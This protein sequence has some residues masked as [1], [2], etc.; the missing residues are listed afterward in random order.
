MVLDQFAVGVDRHH[1]LDLRVRR[2][3]LEHRTL[4]VDDEADTR[5]G[6]LRVAM[7]APGLRDVRERRLRLVVLLPADAILEIEGRA[8]RRHLVRNP[9]RDDV[10]VRLV[11]RR[12]L[13][14]FDAAAAPVA[15]R[16]HPRARPQLVARLQVL[17]VL[18]RAVALH[19][20]EA[21]RIGQRERRDQQPLRIHE[22]PRDPLAGAG[23][24]QQ[25]VGVVDLGPVV[26]R[27]RVLVLAEVRTCSSAA[28]APAS[29]RS[30]AGTRAPSRASASRCPAAAR[31]D[32]RR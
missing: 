28:R 20:A 2:Q 10:V 31:S 27:L 17:V 9:E 22:R 29:S 4:E 6:R 23:L 3:A 5:V 12:D 25:H 30:R 11:G 15:A 24:D 26:A 7:P 19:E 21:E 16:L 1:A 14:E 18:E 32:T 13:H 8:R